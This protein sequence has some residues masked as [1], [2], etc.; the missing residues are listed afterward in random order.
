FPKLIRAEF[1]ALVTIRDIAARWPRSRLHRNP[2]DAPT[3]V[4]CMGIVR[5]G[6][7]VMPATLSRRVLLQRAGAAL[8][9]PSAGGLAG[10]TVFTSASTPLDAAAISVR[11]TLLVATTRRPV[12]EGRAPPWFGTE[13]ASGLNLARAKL[14]PPDQGRFSLTSIGLGDWS[15]SG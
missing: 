1:K 15:L 6:C 2:V 14:V 12:N 10:C 8:V 5:H 9:L 4:L 11:P 13:R 7:E 3:G